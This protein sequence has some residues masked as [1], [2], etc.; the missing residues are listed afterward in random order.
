MNIYKSCSN[1]WAI[2]FRLSRSTI[3]DSWR[4]TISFVYG[5]KTICFMWKKNP[6]RPFKEVY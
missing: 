1:Q 3:Y 6:K 2:G 5:Y 4:W